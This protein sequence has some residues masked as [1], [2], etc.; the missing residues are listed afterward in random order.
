MKKITIIAISKIAMCLL[1]LI[2]LM[3]FEPLMAQSDSTLA[4]QD[5]SYWQKS[6]SGGL[7]FNQASFENWA[8]GGVNSIALGMVL[9]A[10]ALYMKEKWS[11]DNTA[12]LQ[13]GYVRQ[14]GQTRKAADQ[15]LLNSVAGYKLNAKWD[16][17]MSGGFTTF[18]APGYLYGGKKDG[19]GGDSLVS[20]FM[21]PAQ[22]GLA[23][24][25]AYK[26][27]DWFSLR[28]SPFAPRFTFLLADEVRPIVNPATGERGKAYGVD[29][30]KKVRTEWLAFQLQAALNKD[31]TKNIKL[32]VLY[33]LYANYQTLTFDQIDH[34]LNLTLAAKVN[35]YISTTFGVI[36]LYDKDFTDKIQLQQTLGIGLLY[37]VSTFKKK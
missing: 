24:G 20:K 32:N 27:N 22:L 25:L 11:W 15:I 34:R 4:R 33:Q 37:N 13:L 8:G 14:A 3:R 26:P 17:F 35:D 5:T 18:F 2:S 28:L 30:G 1:L 36:M 29:P 9:N 21:A 7:N 12:D 6:F 10:R 16:V 19:S 23:W 31:L